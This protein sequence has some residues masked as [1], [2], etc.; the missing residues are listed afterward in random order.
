MAFDP[1]TGRFIPDQQQAPLAGGQQ[2]PFMQQQQRG[3]IPSTPAFQPG[4]PMQQPPGLMQLA[5]GGQQPGQP[6]QQPG[7]QQPGQVPGQQQPGQQ[8]IGQQQFG[9]QQF[10]TPQTQNLANLQQNVR[11][12]LKDRFGITV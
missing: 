8:Q 11:S 6:M 9:Q 2:L 4:Q 10:A 5:G 12:I 1:V 7:Q 3:A